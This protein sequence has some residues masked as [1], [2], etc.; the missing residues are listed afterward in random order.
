MLQFRKAQV[1]IHKYTDIYICT[2]PF[3]TKCEYIGSLWSILASFYL[4]TNLKFVVSWQKKAFFK[5]NFQSHKIWLRTFK[6]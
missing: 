3:L 4:C 5:L 6:L 1:S 2:S